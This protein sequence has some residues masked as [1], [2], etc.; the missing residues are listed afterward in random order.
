[1]L[2]IVPKGATVLNIHLKESS[3]NGPVFAALVRIAAEER[4][5]LAG[6]AWI[7]LLDGM[8]AREERQAI[9]TDLGRAAGEARR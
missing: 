9:W 8:K 2:G 1:M 4:R 6:M 7:L 5:S 3:K